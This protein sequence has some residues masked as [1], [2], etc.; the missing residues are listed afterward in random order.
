M[1]SSNDLLRRRNECNFA[2]KQNWS[3]EIASKACSLDVV[4]WLMSNSLN[5]SRRSSRDSRNKLNRSHQFHGKIF[6]NVEK[7]RMFFSRKC[8]I[9]QNCPPTV[10]FLT[11]FY[12]FTPFLPHVA[13][14]RR[15]HFRILEFQEGNHCK[16]SNSRLERI[17]PE[18]IAEVEK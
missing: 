17:V 6:P 18:L 15:K 16:S 11:G 14:C 7:T 2:S 8:S 13:R 1:I 9:P 4:H 12:S 3:F 10:G 5:K